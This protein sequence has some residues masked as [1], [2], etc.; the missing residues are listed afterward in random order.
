MKTI[1][2][3]ERKALVIHS[4]HAGR[5]KYFSAALS[6]LQRAGVSLVDVLP[7][8]AFIHAA[9]Q[10]ISWQK[11]GVNM[12]VAAGGDGLIG[13]VLPYAVE[14]SLALG[15]LP[16][17]TANDVARSLDIPQNLAAAADV[18][19]TGPLYTISI[20]AA[21]PLYPLSSLSHHQQTAD[22]SAAELLSSS[23]T[24]LSPL[25]F[26]HALTVGL[27]VLF[28]RMATNPL[29]RL[30]YGRLTY[31]RSLWHAFSTYHPVEAEIHFEGIA[32]YERRGAQPVI[33]NERAILRSRIAQVTAVNAPI[34]WGAFEAAVPGVSLH[35]QLLDIVVFE[36]VCRPLLALRMLRFFSY[37]RQQTPEQP[38]QHEWHARHPILFPAQRTR[39]PGVHHI[40]ARSVT[41]VTPERQQAV[42]LDGEIRAYT[43]IKAQVADQRLQVIVPHST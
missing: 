21:Y 28:S 30:R 41:I 8:A 12:L 31:L 42:T 22:A 14:H 11:D 4:P 25:L 5:S 36:H 32:L 40:Q 34:F 38:E 6:R 39:V 20:G 27:S 10:G 26:A 29:V 23:R 1:L 16:L 15:I 43:P 17:G 35:D 18:L 33:S 24:P 13:G 2:T 7:V 9:E 19:A 3:T 37:L